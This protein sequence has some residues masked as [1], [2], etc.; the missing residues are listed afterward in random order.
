MQELEPH[1]GFAA[2]RNGRIE[3]SKDHLKRMLYGT[4]GLASAWVGG[5][6]YY[7]KSNGTL[8]KVIS[9]DNGPDQFSEG[10][11]RSLVNG[12][13]AYFDRRFR[14]V[15]GPKYDWGFPLQGGRALVG[16]GCKLSPPD[17]EGNQTLL[18]GSW[19]YVD[20]KGKE[21]VPVNLPF[22]DAQQQA[23]H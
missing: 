13:I 9:Y 21:I 20:R 10:V 14:Q 17:S 16:L 11:A 2:E 12:K 23:P 8:L 15:I 19:G 6:W 22:K 4:D 7:I 3:I 5:S 18:G 1:T